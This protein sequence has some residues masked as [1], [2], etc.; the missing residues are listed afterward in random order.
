MDMDT[1]FMF[2]DRLFPKVGDNSW[3]KGIQTMTSV[4][5]QELVIRTNWGLSSGPNPRDFG[6]IWYGLDR[7]IMT[8]KSGERM[9]FNISG[10]VMW[11]FHNVET[12]KDRDG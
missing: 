4:E 11:T 8:G 3:P 10:I 9:L 2:L 7:T 5:L 12:E 6:L 1:K